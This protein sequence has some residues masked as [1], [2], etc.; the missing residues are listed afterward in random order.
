MITSLYNDYSQKSRVFLYP[1]LKIQRG[2]SVTPICTYT[3]WVDHYDHSDYKLICTYHM[4]DDK[5][6]YMF[7]KSKL[8]GNKLFED[9]YHLDEGKGMYVFD[10][11]DFKS[12]WDK[13]LSGKYSTFSDGVKSTILSFFAKS[14][15]NYEYVDSY[16]NP[17]KY[18]DTYSRL[19]NCDRSVLEN[20]IELCD[21]PDLDKETVDV[22]IKSLEFGN[23]S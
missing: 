13:Y 11:Q 7:E 8:F 16:L 3:S 12:D 4:R 23:I 10:Y 15:T 17:S 9:F 19:L 2:V 18:Y 21:K 6:F 14:K 20:V 5:E 1:L 22:K